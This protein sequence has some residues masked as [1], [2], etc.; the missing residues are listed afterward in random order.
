[1]KTKL[2]ILLLLIG[3][4]T[5]ALPTVVQADTPDVPINTTEVPSESYLRK[6][7]RSMAGDNVSPL[8][9]SAQGVSSWIGYGKSWDE[10]LVFPGGD[11]WEEGNAG[12]VG[13]P[14]GDAT[15]PVVLSILLL[16]IGFKRM[17]TSRRKNDI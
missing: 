5:F 3:C 17:T 9:A 16:Y 13:G 10:G 11:E 14:I 2:I 4:F 8:S 1:M 15:L 6:E 12:N 7:K